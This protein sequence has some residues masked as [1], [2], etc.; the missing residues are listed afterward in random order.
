MKSLRPSAGAGR[1]IQLDV[2]QS[3]RRHDQV[4]LT[5]RIKDS[6]QRQRSLELEL[7][8]LEARRLGHM[9]LDAANPS[10]RTSADD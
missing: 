3:K 7:T 4:L 5:L 6:S 10:R 9:L 8:T 1:D 2:E